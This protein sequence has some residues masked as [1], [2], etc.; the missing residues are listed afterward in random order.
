MISQDQATR[1]GSKCR[2]KEEIGIPELLT[3][4][5]RRDLHCHTMSHTFPLLH[6]QQHGAVL[7]RAGLELL[8][9]VAGQGFQQGS[10]LR[11]R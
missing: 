9:G 4:V 11:L 6:T 5:G 7:Y 10:S 3:C 1:K 8:A 2:P